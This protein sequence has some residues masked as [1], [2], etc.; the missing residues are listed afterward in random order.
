MAVT[1]CIFVLIL[2]TKTFQVLLSN[3]TFDIYFNLPGGDKYLIG[4]VYAIY[5][6]HSCS[7]L[8]QVKFS[9]MSRYYRY[10]AG[11]VLLKCLR[12]AVG[13]FKVNKLNQFVRFTKSFQCQNTP[14]SHAWYSQL[15]EY[16]WICTG[17]SLI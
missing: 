8:I 7:A 15:Q 16:L 1:K 3:S 14:R 17:F 10:I 12:V 6:R 11:F 9:D 2:L 5:V 13:E 4:I